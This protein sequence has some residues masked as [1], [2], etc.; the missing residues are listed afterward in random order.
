MNEIY[1]SHEYELYS[2][3]LFI[4]EIGIIILKFASLKCRVHQ[5]VR[6]PATRAGRNRR[7]QISAHKLLPRTKI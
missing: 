2:I 3:S 5:V 4:H 1:P 7:A 6:S